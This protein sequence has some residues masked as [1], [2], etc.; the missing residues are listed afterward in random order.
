MWAA[1]SYI[2]NLLEKSNLKCRNDTF[3]NHTS[4][5]TY[6]WPLQLCWQ[7]PSPQK[8]GNSKKKL[9]SFYFSSNFCLTKKNLQPSIRI[10]HPEILSLICNAI[11]LL[12]T[13]RYH[14]I[15]HPK[16]VLKMCKGKLISEDCLI[17]YLELFLTLKWIMF[18]MSH[19]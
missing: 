15:K 11:N 5:T 8:K 9:L 12:F 13:C 7:S 2:K 3:L 17:Y 18:H 16:I 14:F 10:K 4:F 6:F 19:V 1:S